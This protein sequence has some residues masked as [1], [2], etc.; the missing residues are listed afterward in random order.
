MFCLLVLLGSC[1]KAQTDTLS[2]TG[3]YYANAFA[4][5]IM[6]SYYLW[7]DDIAD[8]LQRW[9][10]SAD[11]VEKVKSVR[12]SQDRWTALYDDYT[13][14][15]GSVT[16]T[17]ETFGLDITAMWADESQTRVAG[18]INYTYA[19]SPARKAGL[20]RGDVILTIDGSDITQDNYKQVLGKLFSASQIKLGMYDGRDIDLVAVKMYED[21]VHTVK[22]LQYAGHKIG[23]LHFTSFTM[24]ACKDLETAFSQFK[25]QGIEDLVLDLR[26]N[27][28]GYAFTSAALATM[29]APASAI[30]EGKVFNQD[31]YNDILSKELAEDTY[32]QATYKMEDNTVI[33]S[34]DVNPGLQRL[35]VLV[36]GGTA[37]ASEALICG[38]KPYM[39]VTLIGAKTYGKFCGGVLVKATEWYK[40][41]E[42]NASSEFDCQEAI[43]LLPL[44]GMYVIISRYADCNGETLSMP[45][46]IPVDIEAEDKPWNETELGDP[47]ESMLAVALQAITGSAPASAPFAAPTKAPAPATLP[48]RRPG[49]GVLL[50]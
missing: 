11:P 10:T 8:K 2:P 5:N 26:Y 3:L 42:K 9:S 45:D 27:G 48:F 20:K 1:K 22:V 41:V 49:F 32:F 6:Q 28:G 38:L 44:W 50:H 43:R 14:F 35:W 39:P 40:A 24:D 47:T 19:D 46:G 12:V 23:Y 30:Q 13:S 17:L 37:S 25:A 4:Y 34:A 29:M 21:P 7:K 33:H 15:E 36:S 31:V 18:V 16:G